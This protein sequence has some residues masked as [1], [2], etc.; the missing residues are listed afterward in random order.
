MQAGE[1]V[2][3]YTPPTLDE[4]E[5]SEKDAIILR[6]HLLFDGTNNNKHNISKRETFE[7]T[8]TESESHKKH[9][10]VGSSYDNGRTNIAVMEPHVVDGKEKG[11][12]SYVV[13]VYVE[14][15]GTEQYEK[16]DTM[17]LALGALKSGVYQRA[18][19]GITVAYNTLVNKFLSKKSPEEYYI[20]QV[21]VDVFGFSRGAATA[22]HAIHAM[23]TEETQAIH[24]PSGYGPM[25]TVV[26]HRPLFDR[27]RLYGYSE[28][29]EENVKYIFAG[30][31]DTVVSVNAS[32]LAPAWLA[33]NA[34]DQ[35]AVAKTKFALHLTSADEHR[36]DFP[37]HKIT[38]AINAG[39]GAE[40]HLP[41]V[42]SDIGGSY[43]LANQALLKP[44][45][46]Q[47]DAEIRELKCVGSFTE[48]YE[49]KQELMKKGYALYDLHISLLTKNIF[50]SDT[51]RLYAFRRID[52][53]EYARPSDE[54]NRIIN[55][56][57]V[58]DL[59]E[60][61]ENL[62]LDGWYNNNDDKNPQIEIDIDYVATAVRTVGAIVNPI[63]ALI[64]GSPKSG[65]L[66]T[67][68]MGITSAYC[69]I[70]L[71]FMVEHSR[72]MALEIDAKLDQ[73]IST[74]LASVP[75]LS[76]IESSL[77]SYMGKKGKTGSKPE[78][79]LDIKEAEKNCPKIKE[80]R[81]KHLHMSSQFSIPV[82]DPGFTP[83][84][85]NNLRR[86]FYYDG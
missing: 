83:R 51:Y 12:Y 1:L 37:L 15:Q 29:K 68:R 16:D 27:L 67:N 18:R 44:G 24:N 31:Y 21:D 28:M 48:C 59:K 43:N 47:S 75:D 76:S 4:S 14:G 71:K 49:E 70:P 86:R 56:G 64:D 39:R 30:L 34:R 85:K 25:M 22:R 57:R 52:G 77:R 66:L 53:L 84:L 69:N 33:N 46:E 73:R 42:H 74:V 58:S 13:K 5:D 45:E 2:H 11:G 63:G 54:E 38:S 82:M 36:Q 65:K 32:Q 72:D 3:V 6:I 81:N 7:S 26:T 10:D 61:M 80:L 55:R 41:G 50:S 35:R 79:W 8:D 40:Y 20:Q 60:D 23:S 19:K 9:G 78:D 62:I 17:G